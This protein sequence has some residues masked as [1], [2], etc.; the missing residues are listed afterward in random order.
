MIANQVKLALGIGAA[1]FTTSTA[2]AAPRPCFL[3]GTKIRTTSG[4]RNVESISAGD[5]VLTASGQAREVQWV[6]SWRAWRREQVAW[7]KHLRPVRISR[8]AIAPD[9]PYADVYVSQGHAIFIDGVLIPAGELVNGTSIT[10]HGARESTELEYFH[11]KLATH[12]VIFACGLPSET[13][14]KYAPD[15]IGD[16]PKADE[17]RGGEVHCAPIVCNG[18]RSRIVARARKWVPWLE[19]HRSEVIRARLRER[20]VAKRNGEVTLGH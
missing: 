13:L 3:R 8:S 12:D 4:E 5:Q 2:K 15:Q 16:D 10:L 20:A 17:W 14:L 9:V 6:G 7:S 19:P 11:I 1:I 18:N